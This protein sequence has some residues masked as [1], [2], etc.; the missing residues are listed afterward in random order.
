MASH[1]GAVV[2]GLG[3]DQSGSPDLRSGRGRRPRRCR[4]GHGASFGDLYLG[5]SPPWCGSHVCSSTRPR[6]PRTWSRTPSST[7]IAIGEACGT[8]AHICIAR[9]STPAGRTT[10]VP[11]AN[12]PARRVPVDLRAEGDHRRLRTAVATSSTAPP[13]KGGPTTPMS[14]APRWPRCLTGSGPPSCSGTTP[15]CPMPRSPSPSG[16]AP[17]PWRLWCTGGSNA[18]ER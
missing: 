13:N 12:A 9:S 17:A 2:T 10:G 1:A 11:G 4:R 5:P 14:S 15:I 8:R 16:A 6:R 7:S 3:P 18:C